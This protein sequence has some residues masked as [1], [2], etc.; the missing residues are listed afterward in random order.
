MQYKGGYMCGL[1]ALYGQ[2]EGSHTFYAKR[3]AIRT[4]VPPLYVMTLP[5]SWWRDFNR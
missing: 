5:S 4:D 2:S 3:L 1:L